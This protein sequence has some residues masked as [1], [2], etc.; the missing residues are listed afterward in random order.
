MENHLGYRLSEHEGGNK[1]K[2]AMYFM[3]KLL[4]LLHL[5]YAVTLLVSLHYQ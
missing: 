1:N 2:L 5:S 3:P 4:P